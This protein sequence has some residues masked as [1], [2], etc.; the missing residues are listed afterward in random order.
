VSALDVED[1]FLA[2]VSPSGS[3][4]VLLRS[5]RPTADLVNAVR[6]NLAKVIASGGSVIR[7]VP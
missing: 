7:F 1:L 4:A 3:E 2:L 5:H 6:L